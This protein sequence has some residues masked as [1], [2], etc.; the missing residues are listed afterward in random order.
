LTIGGSSGAVRIGNS[1]ATADST[2]TLTGTTTAFTGILADTLAFGGSRKLSLAVADGAELTLS[3]DN[4]YTG[5]TSVNGTLTIGLASALG[6]GPVLVNAGGVLDLADL[7]PTALLVLNGGTFL[8]DATWLANRTAVGVGLTSTAA[9]INA[10][11]PS[12]LV[13][14]VTG[15]SANLAG[16]TRD[17][18]FEG[19]AVTGLATFSGDL[20]LAGGTFDLSS[21]VSTQGNLV[22]AGGTVDFANRAAAEDLLFRTGLV[23]NGTNWTGRAILD[24]SGTVNLVNGQLGAATVVIGSGQVASIGLNFANDIRLAGGAI[25]GIT[26]NNYAGTLIVGAGQTF[27]LDGPVN[28]AVAVYVIEAA[29]SAAPNRSNR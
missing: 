1:S 21:S 18:T 25:D 16:V 9:E 20:L 2:L 26:F 22:L 28:N 13:K 11:D 19:G 14:V 17:I 6:S 12:L 23:T 15:I 8:R 3:G 10:L 27:D 29:I 5:G 4:T 7:N 24:A